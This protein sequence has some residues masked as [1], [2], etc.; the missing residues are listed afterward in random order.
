MTRSISMDITGARITRD[1][2]LKRAGG[3]CGSRNPAI[4]QEIPVNG[5]EWDPCENDKKTGRCY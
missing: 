2:P 3:I 5:D 4:Y 1:P